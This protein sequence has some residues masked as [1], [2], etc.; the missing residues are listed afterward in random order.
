MMIH[1][2]H[3]N[4][5]LR[6]MIAALLALMLTD[7]QSS[8]Q[9]RET[10]EPARQQPTTRQTQQPLQQPMQQPFLQPTQQPVQRTV[11]QSTLDA[12]TGSQQSRT[13]KPVLP[14][15]VEWIEWTE[16]VKEDLF[17]GSVRYFLTFVGASFDHERQLPAVLTNRKVGSSNTL[18][19]GQ[20]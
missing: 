15:G 16:P 12:T 7:L 4:H 20:H 10:R 19:A 8:A 14:D 11:P 3:M 18:R 5:L 9:N 1:T 6:S 17:D 13:R 2:P